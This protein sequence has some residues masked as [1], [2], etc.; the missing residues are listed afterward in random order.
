LCCLRPSSRTTTPSAG[1]AGTR[2]FRS[3]AAYTPRLRC[4]GTPRR[5]ASPS[6][7]SLLRFPRVPS[8]IRRRVR[9]R[10]PIAVRSP[11]NRLPR[12]LIES[13]PSKSPSL[14][15]TSDGLLISALHRSLYATARTFAK[16]SG[17]AMT[18]WSH[19]CSTEPSEDL[20]RPRFWR[21]PSPDDAGDQARWVNGK[22]PSSGLSPD[23]SQQ[24]VR[25]HQKI[26]RS[27]SCR[28]DCAFCYA[29]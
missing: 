14:P 13:P 22:S 23:Q 2:G 17:L 5:P 4:A 9:G 20:C 24:L 29:S 1:L 11:D 18:R 26:R 16:P 10:C 8:T 21:R 28:S 7:L 27:I 12:L 15:V 25:L 3:W 19:V 6:L